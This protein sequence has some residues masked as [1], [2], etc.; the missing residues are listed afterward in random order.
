[1]FQFLEHTRIFRKVLEAWHVVTSRYVTV[2]GSPVLPG[3][4]W[5]YPVLPGTTGKVISEESR[6]LE[7]SP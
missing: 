5:R 3:N 2:Y 7:R 4:S 6:D 1:M